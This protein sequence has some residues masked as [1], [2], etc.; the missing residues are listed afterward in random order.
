M[1]A[2]T[3]RFCALLICVVSCLFMLSGCGDSKIEEKQQ[4]IETDTLK[5]TY[6]GYGEEKHGWV[7]NEPDV[8]AYKFK[9]RLENKTDKAISYKADKI[10]I[11][12]ETFDL[13]GLY[14]GCYN[15]IGGNEKKGEQIYIQKEKIEDAGI[16]V[17]EIKKIEIFLRVGENDQKRPDG[18][19]YLFG[20]MD[21]DYPLL[22]S[23]KIVFEF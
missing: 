11:D 20:I 17:D 16:K 21:S 14:N 10:I 1:R 4:T 6:N 3:I 5:V 13:F 9:L 12:G 7:L 23:P 2:K 8:D 22:E 15:S 19:N 18:S